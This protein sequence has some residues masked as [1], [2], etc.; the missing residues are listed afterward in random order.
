MADPAPSFTP[1]NS[2]WAAVRVIAPALLLAM[3]LTRPRSPRMCEPAPNARSVEIC[4]AVSLTAMEAGATGRSAS[5][6][7]LA[8]R[9]LVTTKVPPETLDRMEPAPSLTCVAVTWVSVRVMAPALLLV[10]ETMIVRLPNRSDEPPR[11]MSAA[12]CAAVSLTVRLSGTASNAMAASISATARPV[13]RKVPPVIRSIA[14]P[15]PSLTPASSICALVR[16]IRPLSLTVIA[17]MPPRLARMSDEPEIRSAWI[18]AAVSLM[19]KLAGGTPSATIA[20]I[21]ATVAPVTIRVPPVTF[22]SAEPAPSLTPANSTCAAVRVMAPALLLAML[23]MSSR[24]SRMSDDAPRARSVA[25]CAAVSLTVM[26]AGATPSPNTVSTSATTT[27][28]TTRLPPDSFDSTEPLPS[29]TCA[30]CTRAEVRVIVPASDATM[31]EIS[32]RLA[33]RSDPPEARSAWI[34]AAV[35]LIAIASGTTPRPTRVSMSATVA[36]VTRI[37]PRL[38]FDSAEPAP[39][40]TPV[41]VICATVSA[42]VSSS[43]TWT[44]SRMSRCASIRE[45]LATRSAW[46]LDAKSLMTRLTGLSMASMTASFPANWESASSIVG[47]PLSD[48]VMPVRAP[49]PLMKLD[50]PDIWARTWSAVSRIETS[51]VAVVRLAACVNIDATVS[52][53][54]VTVLMRSAASM[55]AIRVIAVDTCAAVSTMANRTPLPKWVRTSDRPLTRPAVMVRLSVTVMVPITDPR[56]AMAAPC[57]ATAATVSETFSNVS[58]SREGPTGTSRSAIRADTVVVPVR[59][60]INWASRSCI[61]GLVTVAAAIC[62][63]V[64]VTWIEPSVPVQLSRWSKLAMTVAASPTTVTGVP[65]R[66]ERNGNNRAAAAGVWFSGFVSVIDV[67]WLS[68]RMSCRFAATAPT[69]ATVSVTCTMTFSARM[70][71]TWLAAPAALSTTVSVWA[72]RFKSPPR[73]ASTAA[74]APVIEPSAVSL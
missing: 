2:I 7:T 48:S 74:S 50:S 24:W 68:S 55:V 73:A 53:S 9:A 21:C 4:A 42:I 37:S 30:V 27:P 60:T 16:E 46:M 31:V 52:S 62:A 38:S 15:A 36:P 69:W 8:A 54:T 1:A 64:S 41:A 47:V 70:A 10:M 51:A 33:N 49:P 43:A 61:P 34:W 40:S 56:M 66:T 63:A 19:V 25:R 5:V 18:C 17:V 28:V 3:S 11:T 59:V 72:F 14:D 39:S 23:V 57:A 26:E 67:I 65:A 58:A 20:S 29:F 6:P 45:L 13:T 71:A 12:I 32:A 44:T 35:S 22:D